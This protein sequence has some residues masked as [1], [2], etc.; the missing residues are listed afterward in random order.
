[1]S[2]HTCPPDGDC[3]RCEQL[4]DLAEQRAAGYF[5]E[6]EQPDRWGRDPDWH[7]PRGYGGL[8]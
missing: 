1:M 2:R 4:I 5:D 3:P 7:Y 6:I 8:Q